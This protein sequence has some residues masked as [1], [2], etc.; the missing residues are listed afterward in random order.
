M[1][2]LAE[3]HPVHHE[4][5]RFDYQSGHKPRLWTRAPTG[6]VQEAAD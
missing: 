6:R 1:A 4:V 3:G 2:Q 5:I